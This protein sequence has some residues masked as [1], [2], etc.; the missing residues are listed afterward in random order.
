[1]QQHPKHPIMKNSFHHSDPS[2]ASGSGAGR[3]SKPLG[4]LDGPASKGADDGFQVPSCPPPGLGLVGEKLG[5]QVRGGGGAGPT[6]GGEE[7]PGREG[8]RVGEG[9]AG[10]CV[11][12]L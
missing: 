4:T 6:E 8:A 5:A 12:A 7:S 11:R 2:S 1:M 3:N 9:V 10:G